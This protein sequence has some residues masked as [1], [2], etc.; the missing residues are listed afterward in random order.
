[1]E[2][3]NEQIINNEEI[4]KGRGR[5][6]KAD[7][8]KKQRP[9]KYDINYYHNSKYSNT[10]NCDLCNSKVTFAKLLR[11]KRTSMCEKRSLTFINI[12]LDI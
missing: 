5:P 1:M 6:K 10:I 8:D 11:H 4:K 9:E 12:N 3:I 7:E 2:Q